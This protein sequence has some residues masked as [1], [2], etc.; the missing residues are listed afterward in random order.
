MNTYPIQNKIGEENIIKRIMTNNQYSEDIFHKIN[1]RQTKK[2]YHFQNN[3][4]D[5]NKNGLSLCT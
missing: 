3:N 2:K 1:S 5:N 4:K